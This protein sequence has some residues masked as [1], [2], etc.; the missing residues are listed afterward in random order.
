VGLC[1]HVQRDV[2]HAAIQLTHNTVVASWPLVLMLDSRPEDAILEDQ[3]RACLVAMRENVFVC[4]SGMLHFAESDQFQAENEKLAENQ[5]VGLLKRTLGWRDERNL[6]QTSRYMDF[7]DR[8]DHVRKWEDF[9]ELKHARS[10]Q[11]Q[12]RF[13]LGD[14]IAPNAPPEAFR[15][16]TQSLGQAA[17]RDNLDLGANVDRVGPGDPYERWRKTAEY[18]EWL[19]ASR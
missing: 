11:G 5:T 9:W 18:R 4:R 14:V 15:L 12:V 16:Q 6:Y 1:F 8:I 10:L 19:K 3:P 17:G 13:K 7:N 2:P